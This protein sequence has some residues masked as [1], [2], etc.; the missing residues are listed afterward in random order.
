MAT[1]IKQGRTT[2]PGSVSIVRTADPKNLDKKDGRALQRNVDA[3]KC[4]PESDGTTT[5]VQKKEWVEAIENYQY[6]PYVDCEYV[7]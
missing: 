4:S 5:Y 1:I 3:I 6:P 7:N 2:G